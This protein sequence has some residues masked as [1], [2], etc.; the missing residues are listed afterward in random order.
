MVWAWILAM[1]TLFPI[2]TDNR[3]STVYEQLPNGTQVIAFIRPTTP[4]S[5]ASLWVKCGS[6]FDPPNREG[7]AHLLEHLLPLKPFNGTTIQIAIEQEGALLTPETGRDFM[8]FHLQARN[9]TIAKVFPM[10]VEAVSDLTVDLQVVEREKRLMWLETLALHEDPLWLMKTA[11]EARL[12]EGTP[13]AHPPTG[14]LETLSQLSFADAQQLHCAHFIAPNFA[15]VAVVPS[16]ETLTI[17]KEATNKLP[18][19]TE[20]TATPMS[21]PSQLFSP[22]F[23]AAIQKALTRPNEV[24]WGIGWRIAVEAK[25]KVVLDAIVLHLRQVLLPTLFGQIGVV[26]EWNM[27]ANPVH[28]EV[29]LTIIARL[30]PYTEL[31][32]R[33]LKWALSELSKRDLSATELNF[34]KRGLRLEHFRTLNNP[35]RCVRELGWAWALYG[36]PTIVERYDE[37]L[38]S[39]KPEQIRQLASRLNSAKPVVWMVGR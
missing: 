21:L 8:A 11:I 19:T 1:Q 32:E 36:D 4:Y 14:W 10:L 13:Y 6:A 27:L 30:R 17:L 28:G 25:E 23:E 7:T 3:F 15:L 9:E 29:A 38:E 18:T 33:R 5:V 34:L 24:F 39:L 16:K 12:F 35:A 31:I 37:M 22:S 26:Q 20:V 2:L